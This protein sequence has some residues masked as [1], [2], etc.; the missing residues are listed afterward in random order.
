MINITL[1]DGSVRQYEAG[2]TSMQ[3]AESIS[4]G[5]ARNVLSAKVNGA[6]WDADRPVNSDSLVQLLTWRDKD[7]KMTFWHSTA[8]L[9]AEAI[10]AV[11]PGVKFGTGPAIDD[12]FY[13][14]IDPGDHKSQK[15]I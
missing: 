3:V 2:V 4:A 6:V 13:Y 1:P 12:G 5:L 14:D 8:H 7:G 9:M 15:V 10:E 11:Y